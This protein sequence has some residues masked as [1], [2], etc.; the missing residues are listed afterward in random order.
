MENAT[1]KNPKVH[2]EYFCE[3]CDYITI[4]KRDYNKHII[5]RKHRNAT[6]ATSNATSKC[7]NNTN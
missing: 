2:K 3:T 4:S 1:L 7:P 6:N 5:T